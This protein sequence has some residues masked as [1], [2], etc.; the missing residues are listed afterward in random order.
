MAKIAPNK[1]QGVGQALIND[2]ISA[3]T[4]RL[5]GAEGQAL[6]IVSLAQALEVSGNAGL[7]LV[8]ISPESDPPVCKVL[9]YGKYRYELQ[10]KKNESKKKQKI[11]GVKEV[12]LRPYIG[13]NDLL[14]KCKAIKKF[15]EAGNKVKVVLRFRGREL[16][17]QDIGAEVLKKMMEICGDFCKEDSPPKLDGSVMIVMLSSK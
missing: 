12:Q 14:I 7:D 3:S 10:K 13:E 2:E 6:G 16:R 17:H 5:I 1:K 8:L 4:V 9:D 15:T 11:V